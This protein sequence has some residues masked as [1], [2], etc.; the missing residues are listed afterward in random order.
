MNSAST[1]EWKNKFHSIELQDNIKGLPRLFE[2]LQ[3][4]CRGYTVE[5]YIVIWI[6]TVLCQPRFK[7]DR[8]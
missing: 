7:S 8:T 5:V 3:V 4:G 1:E 2:D 6:C